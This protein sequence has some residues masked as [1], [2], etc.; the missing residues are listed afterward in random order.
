MDWKNTLDKLKFRLLPGDGFSI[1][2]HDSPDGHVIR[3]IQGNQ[4]LTLMVTKNDETHR[5]GRYL[6]IFPTLVRVLRIPK[7]VA[8]DDGQPL[9]M[10]QALIAMDR[11]RTSVQNNSGRFKLVIDDKFYEEVQRSLDN[12]K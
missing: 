10:E 7:S 4:Q 2:I 6:R 9:T 5:W 1:M 11:I 3:Y 8:W 12:L